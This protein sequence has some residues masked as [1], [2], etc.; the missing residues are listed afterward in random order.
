MYEGAAETWREWG[1]SLDLKDA[2]SPGQVWGEVGL[3]LAT[4][5]LPMPIAI[6]L[7][8]YQ[9]LGHH[10]LTLTLA[11]A[12]NLA[13]IGLRFALLLAI[14]PSYARPKDAYPACWLFW[15]SPLADPLAVWRIVLSA[16]QT[17]K[18]WRG[19][20]YQPFAPTDGDAH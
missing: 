19:R 12:L 16:L 7:L 14:Y 2:A 9:S 17:P 11:I 6:T 20:Q 18:Q 13:A 1:R 4:Q 3:L 10:F 8:T 5:G 15:L